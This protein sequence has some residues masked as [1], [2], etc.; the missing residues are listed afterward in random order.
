MTR[1]KDTKV[2]CGCCVEPN[3]AG[4]LIP[5]EYFNLMSILTDKSSKFFSKQNRKQLRLNK[6]GEPDLS[7]RFGSYAYTLTELLKAAM[8][9]SRID[10]LSLDVE[11]VELSVLKDIDFG[12]YTFKYILVE[13]SQEPEVTEILQ[14]HNQ[15]LYERIAG[16][17][18]LF[19]RKTH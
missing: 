6:G 11:G 15:E 10:F 1:S 2:F 5:K 19:P 12:I 8:A 4:E 18:L 3:K 13:T 14:E 16:H 17:G 9:P 7:Y